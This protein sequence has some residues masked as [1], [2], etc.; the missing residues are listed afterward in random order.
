MLLPSLDLEL[1]YWR[2]RRR[3][4]RLRGAYRYRMSAARAQAHLRFLTWFGR[5]PEQPQPEDTRA[6]RL[7]WA[8]VI[9]G[10]AAVITIDSTIGEDEFISRV[11]ATVAAIKGLPQRRPEAQAV[12]HQAPPATVE[13]PSERVAIWLKKSI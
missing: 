7:M 6:Y 9:T 13:V 12:V 11:D 2:L 10:L 5:L 3:L 4:Q 1:T 8:I